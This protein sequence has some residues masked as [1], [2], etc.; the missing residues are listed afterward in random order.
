MGAPIPRW[1]Y[2]SR[3]ARTL[4]I[5]VVAATG[6]AAAVI[7]WPHPA[8]ADLRPGVD[9]GEYTYGQGTTCAMGASDSWVDP[10]SVVFHGYDSGADYN[11]V[12]SHAGDHG[13]WGYHQGSTQ[14]FLTHG[15]CRPHD[16]QSNS[17]NQIGCQPQYHMRYLTGRTSSG[18]YDYDPYDGYYT[19]AS[20]HH[21]ECSLCGHSVD[22]N[23]GS[24]YGGGFNMGRED[25]RKN[26]VNTG[27]H[28]Y[29]H[30]EYWDNKHR[31]EQCDD[32]TAWS[33]GEVM[34]VEIPSCGD[35]SPGCCCK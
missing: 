27:Y 5:G 31:F 26:W 1:V 20:P 23:S 17:N 25:I 21:E 18:S 32:G 7:A 2:D 28:P 35:Y 3:L 14:Y 24:D 6:T 34:F 19:L 10:I 29:G 4:G 13:G 11:R 16:Q 33:S 22:D 8:Q 15:W 12:A 9:T 30:T